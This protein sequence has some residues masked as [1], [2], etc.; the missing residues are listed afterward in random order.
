M[1]SLQREEEAE[2]IHL[3]AL[4]AQRIAEEEELTV[5]TEEKKS[6]KVSLL[7][8]RS[9][10]KRNKAKTAITAKDLHDELL[11]DQGSWKLNQLWKLSF[12]EVKEEFD[13]L[14]NRL[15]LLHGNKKGMHTS[16]DENVSEDSD[17]VDEQEETNT[18]TETPLNPVPVAMKTPSVATYKIIKQGEKGV[19]HPPNVKG[20]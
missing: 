10:A 11:K 3:D 14:I 17:K 16:V 6:S 20:I 19:Y 4:L 18:G 5:Q 12:E 9:K 7:K 2:Q 13:K 8:E 15:S 1:D